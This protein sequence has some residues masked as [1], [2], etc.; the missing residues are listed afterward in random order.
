MYAPTNKAFKLLLWSSLSA[1]CRLSVI[2]ACSQSIFFAGNTQSGT[3]GPDSPSFLARLAAAPP[4]PAWMCDSDCILPSYDDSSTAAWWS[5]RCMG[6]PWSLSRLARQPNSIKVAAGLAPP[7]ARLPPPRP[8]SAHALLQGVPAST[9][10]HK[11]TWPTSRRIPPVAQAT[12]LL[13]RLP[14][15]KKK[16]LK[17]RKQALKRLDTHKKL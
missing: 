14:P 6:S 5:S 15:S 7:T 16:T 13:P 2:W 17:I 4:V 10:P 12:R 9:P 8:P 11:C 3:A 1:L